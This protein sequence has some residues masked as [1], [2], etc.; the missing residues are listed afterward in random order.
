MRHRAS[1]FASIMWAFSIVV[2]FTSAAL[3]EEPC[4]GVFPPAV[5]VLY[6]IPG[7]EPG[8]KPV[9]NDMEVVSVAVP[10]NREPFA[11]SV[12]F[13][14][15]VRFPAEQGDQSFRFM[16]NSTSYY[17]D[18]FTGGQTFIS[19]AVNGDRFDASITFP[20]GFI[21]TFNTVTFVSNFNGQSN[22]FLFPTAVCGTTSIQIIWFVQSQCSVGNFTGKWLANGVQFFSGQYNQLPQ[23]P[24]GK[25]PLY[26][27]GAFADA[28]DTICRTGTQRDVHRCDGRV[29]EVPWTIAAK[30]CAMTS[31]AMVLSYHGINVTPPTLNTWLTANNGYDL[32]GNVMWNGISRYAASRGGRLTYLGAGGNLENAICTNGPHIISVRNGGH[33]VTATGRDAA[34]TTFNIN[35]PNG[36]VETTL[37][38][39]Y[40]NTF[41]AIRRFAGPEFSITD[42]NGI[43]C[44]FHSPGEVL[45]ADPLGRRTGLDPL[46]GQ[47]FSEI[48][49]STYDTI[50]LDDESDPA[51]PVPGPDTK[52]L[53]IQRAIDGEYSLTVTGTGTGTYD[54]EIHAFDANQSPSQN[55]FLSVPIS[56]GVVHKYVFD[57]S[58]VPG[59]QISV[60]GGF[61]GGG[62]RPRDVNKFLSYIIPGDSPTTLPPGTTTTTI[63]IV[64]G[65]TIIPSSF[66]AQLN[67]VNVAGL[68]SA[69]PGSSQMVT[70][71]LQP[72]RNVLVLSV[73]GSL[74]SRVARDTDRLVFIVQ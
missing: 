61:D 23:I 39:R 5:K 12:A 72:G 3:G 1:N 56:P 71:N 35:D 50:G 52:D 13:E 67:G 9:E 24:P 4:T 37:A 34:R 66:A 36:G 28:Y 15:F 38:L 44:R 14:G 21:A 2:L 16:T 11:S 10:P 31:A 65:K 6:R 43:V 70:L 74:P 17:R 73:E 64:Y 25:V 40:N 57:Y 7:A 8:F 55:T 60:G 69:T 53:D 46:T 22:C 47:T 20:N 49:G 48:P 54:L 41:G 30:G 51:N 45:I 19:S 18:A 26:N 29:G 33:W 63:F 59:S 68:F 58:K 27:Q 62:Q 32:R 42:V